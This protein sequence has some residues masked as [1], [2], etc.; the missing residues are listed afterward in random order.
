MVA[1]PA[2]YHDLFER[3]TI[4]HVAT[5]MPDGTPHVTPVW[6]D[7]DPYTEH[8]L[9]NTER[10]RQKAATV[11]RNPKIGLSMTDPDDPYRR[12]S[13]MGVVAEATAEGAREHIDE[14]SRR[15]TGR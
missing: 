10:G 6:I 5:V 1:I 12:L 9:V 4:A 3:D 15:Y 14:L 8:V 11:E 13:V 2:E 7:Y